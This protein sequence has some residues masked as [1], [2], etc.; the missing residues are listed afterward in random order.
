MFPIDARPANPAESDLVLEILDD[1]ARWLVARGIRQWDSPPADGLVRLILQ[2]I[3]SGL[4]YLII[5]AG[6]GEIAGTFR[7]TWNGQPR[8]TDDAD[9]GY[10]YSLALRPQHIGEGIGTATVDWVIKH[11]VGLGKDRLRVDCIST[12]QR[13]RTWYETQGFINRGVIKDGSYELALYELDL[14]NNADGT[15]DSSI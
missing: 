13:L 7:L 14:S 4:V 6:S 3:R 15:Q 2:D 1:A 10:L 8:W 5:K 12:N 9:A 11:L